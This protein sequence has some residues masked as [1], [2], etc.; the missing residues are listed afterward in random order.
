MATLAIIALSA[1]TWWLATRGG[2]ERIEGEL[3]DRLTI[4]LRSVE[5]EI[6]RFRYL[7]DIVGHDERIADVLAHAGD[8]R[9]VAIA[10]DYLQTVRAMSGADELYVLDTSGL[11]LAASNWNEPGSFV[12]NN[13]GF[14]PYFRDA[15]SGGEGRYYAVGVTTGKPGY[16]LSAQIDGAVGPVGIV[17]AKVDMSP[18]AETWAK[19]GE[20][21]GIADAAG[22]VFLSGEP[23]WA[24]RPLYP[25]TEATLAALAAERRY[26]GIDV[27]SR[28]TI[29]PQ[30]V[31]AG[32]TK[33][34]E[35]DGVSL[36]AGVAAIEPDGWQ[37]ISALPMR[38]VHEKARLVAGLAALA[39]LLVS[40]AGLYLNQR[41]QITRMKLEQN[42]VLERRVAERTK[43]LA[44]EVEER[45]R[46]EMELRETQ[47][48]LIHAAKLAALGRMSAAIVHEVSQPLSALDSTLAAAG[49]HAER[50]SKAEVQRNLG[51]ARDL[52]KRMQRTVKH[53][54]TFSSRR[55]MSPPEAV[56]IGTVIDAAI[57]IV[58]PRARE[59]GVAMQFQRSAKL[60][61]ASGNPIRL[62]Q[63]FINLLLN[64]VDATATAGNASVTVTAASMGKRMQVRI[65]DA[66]A[67]I[68]DAVRERMFEPFFTTKT[69][70]EGLG[71]GLSITR[72]ILEESGGT[73]SF[74]PIAA[75]GTLT[76]VELPNY[77]RRAAPAGL[78]TA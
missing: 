13:Y 52:L 30:A 47:E 37:L 28:P 41:R 23:S 61:P 57:E 53:L 36:M 24:Y 64:A 66:G 15:M 26:D 43:A 16:F 9:A 19:A 3:R 38:Q 78:V 35:A 51:S 17:V 72:T 65:A 11:T 6:E 34:I 21:T 25:P 63:V 55:D 10:N 54:K 59:V 27:A 14:R 8:P 69:T 31:P 73:L 1:A 70:G 12:G 48:S 7:P 29:A 2:I 74:T 20:L 58:M 68:P 46:A 76:T 44:H 50:E 67:G 39:G 32:S 62:E 75:G 45:T 4:N 5:S 49:L 60:P 56:D 22:I 40:A 18:L 77:V 33:V 71:L 42:A